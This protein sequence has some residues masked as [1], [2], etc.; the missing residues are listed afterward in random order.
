MRTNSQVV[1]GFWGYDT[2]GGKRVFD[3]PCQGRLYELLEG[4]VSGGGADALPIQW[5]SDKV[6][7]FKSGDQSYY[8]TTT[9]YYNRISNP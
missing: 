3:H 7:P 5:W 1:R 6:S 8:H 9:G 4:L 2:A